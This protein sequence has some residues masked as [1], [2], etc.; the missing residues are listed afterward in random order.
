MSIE[1]NDTGR[2]RKRKAAAQ[3]E[4]YVLCAGKPGP[5]DCR[6]IFEKASGDKNGGTGRS[7]GI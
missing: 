2:N 6:A 7:T 4:C 3:F 5:V 1:E